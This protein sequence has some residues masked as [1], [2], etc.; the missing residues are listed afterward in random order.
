[1]NKSKKQKKVTIQPGCI[2]CGCCQ[3]LVPEVFQLAPCAQIK[4]D[5]DL[6]QHWEKIKS[7]ARQCPVGVIYIEE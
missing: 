4:K 2:S 6:T 1:M 3:Y 7:A 5:A